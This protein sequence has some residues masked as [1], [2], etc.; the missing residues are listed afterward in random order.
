MIQKVD[1]ALARFETWLIVG[2]VAVMLSMTTLQVVLKLLGLPIIQIEE[3]A[4]FLVI[5][6][7]FAGGAVAAHQ[8]RH[9]N[10]DIVSRFLKGWV[11]RVCMPAV[12]L[13]GVAITLVLLRTAVSYVFT[14]EHSLLHDGDIALSIGEP[15]SA[16]NVPGWLAAVIMPVALALIAIHFLFGALYAAAGVE[17]PGQ[18][19][20]EMPGQ[21]SRDTAGPGTSVVAG[22]TPD[23]AV[24]GNDGG[25]A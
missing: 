7:G 9:I 13:V 11:R 12:W 2:V 5:W 19:V 17:G 8:S 1:R 22:A 14:A 16:V 24:A 21:A 15:G 3:G 4:R 10:I 25:A 18:A 6:V 23:D 20:Q